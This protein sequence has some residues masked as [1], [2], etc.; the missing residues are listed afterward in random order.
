MTN[1]ERIKVLLLIKGLGVG[2]AERLLERAIPYFDRRRFEYQVGYF[3]PWK[4]ALRRSFEAASIP[5]HC[6]NLHGL[7]ALSAPGRLTRLLRH[8]RI[9]VVHAHLPLPSVLA[10]VVKRVAGVRGLVY[11]EHNVPERYRA[12]TRLLNRTTYRM[13]DAVI[14]VSREVQARVQ[15]YVHRG[16][17]RLVTIPNAVDPE[18]VEAEV[19]TRGELCR[20]FGFPDDAL[21]VVNVANL[22]PKKGHH[23]LLAAA[24]RVIDQEP[25]ARFLFIGLGPLQAQLAEETR[26]VS[27]NGHVVFAGFR[28]DAVKLMGA[29]DVFVLASLHEGLPVSLLE[30]MALGKPSVVTRVGGVPEVVVPEE[31]AI[32]VEPADVDGLAAGLLSLLR[33]PARRQRMGESARHLVRRRYGMPQMVAAVEDVYRQVVSQ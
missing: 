3:L 8:E 25:R 2:G 24:R 14:G 6:L 22:V 12:L 17:P 19:W 28:D 15:P 9:D 21:V 5:V 32:L 16:R 13:N 33:D 29:A 18:M 23:Y 1:D 11:T 26:R 10:R 4:N 31:T 7:A 27:P 30:A 20:E